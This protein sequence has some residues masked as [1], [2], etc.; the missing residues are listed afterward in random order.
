MSELTYS[1]AYSDVAF[2]N[3]LATQISINA[4]DSIQSIQTLF[5]DNSNSPRH[6]RE[7]DDTRMYIFALQPGSSHPCSF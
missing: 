1:E 2:E 7:G 5:D 3:K 6:G 4:S